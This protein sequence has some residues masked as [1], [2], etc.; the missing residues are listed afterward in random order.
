[1]EG[2]WGKVNGLKF[3]PVKYPDKKGVIRPCYSL[4]QL[5]FLYVI[6]K[7]SNEMRA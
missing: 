2:A 4:N 3:E 1:M 5:E 7:Y 6:T